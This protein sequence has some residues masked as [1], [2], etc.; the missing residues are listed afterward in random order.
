MIALILLGVVL[1]GA[2]VI[3]VLISTDNDRRI[4][5]S[6]IFFLLG[7]LLIFFGTGA[8]SEKTTYKKALDNNP[9]KKEYIYKQIDS[10]YIAVD[11]VYIKKEDYE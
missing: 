10:T 11:S 1:L 5:L 7:V 6:E 2:V 3:I 9:Y 4:V 8:Y